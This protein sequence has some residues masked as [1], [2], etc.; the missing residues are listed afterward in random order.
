MTKPFKKRLRGHALDKL[1][2]LQLALIP[3]LQGTS[4]SKD[5]QYFSRDDERMLNAFETQLW[6]VTKMMRSTLIKAYEGKELTQAQ[7][8]R[9]P[10][11]VKESLGINLKK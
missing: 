9:L 11:S 4:K 6:A 7:E 10:I 1:E 3:L 8:R 5:I 2:A